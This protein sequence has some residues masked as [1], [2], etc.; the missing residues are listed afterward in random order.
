MTG[1][2]WLALATLMTVPVIDAAL[3]PYLSYRSIVYIAGGFAGILGLCLLLPQ[4]LLGARVLPGLGPMAAARW[5]QRIGIALVFCVVVHVVGL[6]LTSPMDTI[7]VLLLRAPTPFSLYGFL[8]FWGVVLTAL[9]V[10]L[11]RVI[12]VRPRVWLWGHNLLALGVVIATAIHA[13]RIQG[14][15][16]AVS[17]AVLVGAVVV[18]TLASLIDLRLVRP[19]R[20]KRVRP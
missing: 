16:G 8:A 17:K 6:Y 12:R 4:P 15:M 7:D 14:A 2:I 19:L 9:L 18:A 10:A 1:L 20:R 13:L 5:H 11:R 3:S